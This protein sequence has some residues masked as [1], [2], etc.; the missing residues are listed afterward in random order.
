MAKLKLKLD[1]NI[2]RSFLLLLVS[3]TCLK[4]SNVIFYFQR[5]RMLLGS[6]TRIQNGN[7]SQLGSLKTTVEVL[8]PVGNRRSDL[9][10]T[11]PRNLRILNSISNAKV[12]ISIYADHENIHEWCKN[13]F[14][15]YLRAGKLRLIQTNEKTFN[16]AQAVNVAVT[17]S[18]CDYLLILDADTIIISSEQFTNAL[19]DLLHSRQ[20]IYS[21][22]YWGTQFLSKKTFITSGGMCKCLQ[23]HD[24]LFTK[25]V[26]GDDLD[27]I[28]RVL[29]N[30]FP[31]N[32]WFTYSSL[33][34][35]LHI[36]TVLNGNLLIIWRT[37]N[38]RT[39]VVRHLREVAAKDRPKGD[40]GKSLFFSR[41]EG[42][43]NRKD[44]ALLR[45]FYWKR[46]NCCC[47]IEF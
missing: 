7:D 36:R 29:A 41:I 17:N 33:E 10:E 4:I 32:A 27:L 37:K 11:L 26:Y 23:I 5:K 28:C 45:Y 12:A 22:D 19:V 44:D 40:Y 2:S 30:N 18:Q 9:R 13:T 43:S 39:P 24:S 21:L 31:S 46:A 35:N 15:D 16:K 8:I 47:F 6:S 3:R 38:R 14:G 20:N 1:A 34:W 25:G 42:F